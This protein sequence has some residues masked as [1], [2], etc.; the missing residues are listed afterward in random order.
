LPR[1]DAGFGRLADG[2]RCRRPPAPRR[3]YTSKEELWGHFLRGG[4]FEGRHHR[5]NCQQPLAES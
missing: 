2:A 1:Q 4:A 5:F 3:H